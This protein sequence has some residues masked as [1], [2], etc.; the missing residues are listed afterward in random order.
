MRK[1]QNQVA[2]NPIRHLRG[3]EQQQSTHSRRR[4]I[5]YQHLTGVHQAMTEL[6]GIH[7]REPQP[8]V[9]AYDIAARMNLTNGHRERWRLHPSVEGAT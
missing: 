8:N 1:L 4:G 3:H 6:E 9:D 7:G 2:A 5:H